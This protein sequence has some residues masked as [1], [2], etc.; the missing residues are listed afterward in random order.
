MFRFDNKHYDVVKLS[1]FSLVDGAHHNV[2][3]GD[4]TEVFNGGLK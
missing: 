3:I 2:G 1:S 4:I